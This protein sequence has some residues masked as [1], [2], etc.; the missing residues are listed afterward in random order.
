MSSKGT[1]LD[2][3]GLD[4][5]W[6]NA[7]NEDRRRDKLGECTPD[8]FEGVIDQLEKEWFN[9]VSTCYLSLSVSLIH[10]HPSLTRSKAYL[11]PPLRTRPFRKTRP[12]PSATIPNA[13]TATP[14]SFAT[15]ATWPCIKASKK[16]SA[17]PCTQSLIELACRLLWYTLYPRGTMA[18]S[19][20]PRLAREPGLV[21]VLPERGRCLQADQHQQVGPPAVRDLDPR[22]RPEQQRLH[23]TD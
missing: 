12:A 11:S 5:L 22:G 23:G 9:L 3:H 2:M 13:K 6:L 8:V 20:M 18:V 17:A 4:E 1:G 21:P 19:E 16:E 7:L 14:L 15:A 10:P